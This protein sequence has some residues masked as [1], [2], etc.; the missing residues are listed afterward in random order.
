MDNLYTKLTDLVGEKI[1]RSD[2]SEKLYTLE[3][4]RNDII[5]KC[6]AELA[7]IHKDDANFAREKWQVWVPLAIYNVLDSFQK[8]SSIPAVRLFME[9]HGFTISDEPV[10]EGIGAG[11][12]R[13]GGVVTDR[14]STGTPQV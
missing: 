13:V 4:Q 8:D 5:M 6:A 1:G 12:T 10:R 9:R 7:R 3:N 11:T 14:G 2:E